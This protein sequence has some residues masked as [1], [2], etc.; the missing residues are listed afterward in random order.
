MKKLQKVRQ[1]VEAMT[2][3]TG[4][5]ELNEKDQYTVTLK[6]DDTKLGIQFLI[7]GNRVN[8]FTDDNDAKAKSNGIALNDV[9]VK[10]TFGNES[11]NLFDKDSKQK[12]CCAVLLDA[13]QTKL[14]KQ[15]ANDNKEIKVFFARPVMKVAE[16]PKKEGAA[17]RRRLSTLDRLLRE[18]RMAEC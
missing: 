4:E 17:K 2:F 14:L 18:I 7:N 15:S 9:V 11:F 8:K 5:G 12:S 3:R 13:W 1:R 16:L 6:K 10:M